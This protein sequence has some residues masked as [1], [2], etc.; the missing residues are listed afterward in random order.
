[1]SQL[2]EYSVNCDYLREKFNLSENV[3]LYEMVNTAVDHIR[4]FE[5]EEKL[6]N[7]AEENKPE[8]KS[9]KGEEKCQKTRTKKKVSRST[10]QK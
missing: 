10:K 8:T 9:L 1:M 5:D 7:L 4:K 6:K 2:A 3:G